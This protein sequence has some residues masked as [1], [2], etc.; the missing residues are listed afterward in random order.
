[1]NESGTPKTDTLYGRAMRFNDGPDVSVL[2]YDIMAELAR[3]L[4]R[5]VARLQ[6][7]IDDILQ[8]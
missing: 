4:E 1:M 3:E 5:E 7:E 2:E 8:Y 6:V